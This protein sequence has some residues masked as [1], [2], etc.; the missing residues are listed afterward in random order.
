MSDAANNDAPAPAARRGP[1]A[2]LAD[3][4]RLA[5]VSTKTVSRVVAGEPNVAPT[6]RETVLAAAEHLQ[7]RPNRLARSLRTGG[8]STTVG[9]VVGD[10]ANPFYAAVAGGAERALAAHG[11]TLLIAAT[12]DDPAA[13]RPVVDALLAER[14][15]GLLLVPVAPDQSYLEAEQRLGTPVVAVDRAAR[16]LD[17]DTVLLDNRRGATA[18]VRTLIAAGHREIAFLG[19]GGSLPTQQDRLAGYRD[20]L[21]D[22]GIP[23]R[24]DLARMGPYPAGLDAAALD[25]LTGPGRPTA[26]LA[27]DNRASAAVVRA[28]GAPLDVDL[29]G[30]D[31]FEL[32]DALGVSAV[33]YDA[34]QIGREAAH[35]LLQRLDVPDAQA[36]LRIVETHVVRRGR[37]TP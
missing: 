33:G 25:L 7:F 21:A 9:F 16:G 30:F 34:A 36:R 6:T 15:R 31:D 10:L 3:V 1:R 37:L 12:E 35:L 8:I 27:G 28:A 14:V 18:A 32:A 17:V 4:A 20:A 13:E 22:A 5:G 23:D 11:L 19:T 26:V 29:V 2:R 24:P